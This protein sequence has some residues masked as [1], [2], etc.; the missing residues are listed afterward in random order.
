MLA[1]H[2]AAIH[3][4]EDHFYDRPN[5]ESWAF[6][7]APEGYGRAMADGE[8]FELV[9]DASGKIIAFCG[10]KN[11][12]VFGLYVHP[13]AQGRGIG[14]VLLQRAEARLVSEGYSV[15]PLTASLNARAFYEVHGW[16]F[17][18]HREVKSRG[19]LIQAVAAMK[20][21]IGSEG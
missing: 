3:A 15:I 1:V 5:R 11:G 21:T 8:I 12:E 20:K 2:L 19:G 14:K 9:E 16:Q 4:I 7:L 6:G 17:I 10:V 18:E 13:D